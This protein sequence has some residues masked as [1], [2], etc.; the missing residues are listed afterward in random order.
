MKVMSKTRWRALLSAGFFWFIGAPVAL[1]VELPADLVEALAS[2]EFK[3]RQRAEAGLFE[4]ARS[5]DPEARGLLLRLH[6]SADD[7]EVR[8]RSLEV[9]KSLVTLDYLKEGSGM[10]GIT[11]DRILVPLP[12]EDP[13]R[14]GILIKEVRPGTPAHEVGLLV[15]DIIVSLN[16]LGASATEELTARISAMK[17]GTEVELKIRRGDEVFD[18]KLR[19]MRKP[20]QIDFNQFLPDIFDIEGSDRAAKDAFFRDWMSRQP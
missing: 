13:P 9:L 1:S 11:M 6:R 15:G 20:P 2:E 16:G 19:L 5:Q 14:E 18:Q 4:W 10:I 7:P 3:E 8:H 17:P 12:G